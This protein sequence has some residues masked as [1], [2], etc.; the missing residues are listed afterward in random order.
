[1]LN[2][3]VVLFIA[4]VLIFVGIFKPNLSFIVPNKTVDVIVNP[5][6]EVSRP[7]DEVLLEK[8]QAVTK[9]FDGSAFDR[10]KDG[11]RLALLYLDLATLIELD[12]EQEV[13]KTTE[14]IRQANSLSG[15]MLRLNLKGTYPGLSDAA[16]DLLV[17]QIGEDIVPLDSNLRA[18][19]VDAFRAL[20][21]ACFEGSK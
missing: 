1:M 5:D 4:G 13:V 17:S 3:K 21:W 2:S 6:L 16:N 7:I 19:A 8:A 12:G 10:N 11:Q 15:T 18:K 9:A 14:E 20:A